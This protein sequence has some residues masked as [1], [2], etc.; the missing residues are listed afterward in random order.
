MENFKPNPDTTIHESMLTT[1][2]SAIVGGSLKPGARLPIRT[3]LEKQF[4]VSRMT[5]QKALDRLT[6]DGFVRSRGHLGTFVT[7]YP[8]CFHRYGIV[9][10]TSP[11][12]H[13]WGGYRDALLGVAEEFNHPPEREVTCYFGVD[14]EGSGEYASLLDDIESKRLAGLLFTTGPWNL[15]KSPVV[16]QKHIPA[17]MVAS[18]QLDSGPLEHLSV[19]HID[20]TSLMEMAVATLAGKGCKRPAVLIGEGYDLALPRLLGALKKQDLPY[21]PAHLQGVSTN[22]CALAEHV[23]QLWMQLSP[24][25]RPDGLFVADDNLADWACSGLRHAGV[26]PNSDLPVMVACNFPDRAVA[27]LAVDRIGF[28]LRSLVRQFIESSDARRSGKPNPTEISLSAV[29]EADISSAPFDRKLS[30]VE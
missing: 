10:N 4:G 24:D 29:L 8:P 20:R 25:L 26:Q 30:A 14:R 9:F 7:E 11:G 15:T 28:D 22:Y 1:F 18:R 3:E 17:M 21:V 6:Q 19:L 12:D 16:S 5:V 13:T 23:T 27:D 2:R